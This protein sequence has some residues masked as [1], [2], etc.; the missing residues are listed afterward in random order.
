MAVPPFTGDARKSLGRALG[1]AEADNG[2]LKL[3]RWRAGVTTEV[4]ITLPVMGAY[5]DT[6]P[7]NCPKSAKVMANAAK[8]LAQRINTNGW[9]NDDGSAAV[10]ALAS[11]SPVRASA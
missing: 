2:V 11:S 7:F 3:K 1:A 4:S 6:A 5:A 9:G 10:S 8:S